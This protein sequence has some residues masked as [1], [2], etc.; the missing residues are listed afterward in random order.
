MDDSFSHSFPEP[1][2]EDSGAGPTNPQDWREQDPL[3]PFYQERESYYPQDFYI[4][5][6]DLPAAAR[7]LIWRE[8]E[9]AAYLYSNQERWRARLPNLAMVGVARRPWNRLPY[10]PGRQVEEKYL[11]WT[12]KAQALIGKFSNALDQEKPDYRHA[13]DLCKQI[14]AHNPLRRS[15]LLVGV[16]SFTPPWDALPDAFLQLDQPPVVDLPSR[17]DL[18]RFGLPSF[19]PLVAEPIQPVAP[20]SGYPGQVVTGAVQSGI[21]VAGQ[22]GRTGTLTAVGSQSGTT[23]LLGARHVLGSPNDVLSWNNS[24]IGEVIQELPDWDAALACVDPG[25]STADDI[26]GLTLRPAQPMPVSSLVQDVLFYGAT[27]GAHTT[28]AVLDQ[29]YARPDPALAWQIGNIDGFTIKGHAKHGDSGALIL[30]GGNRPGLSLNPSLALLYSDSMLG[31]LIA[32]P[33]DDSDA[34]MPNTFF[35]RSVFEIAGRL[36]L[37]FP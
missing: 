20:Y 8:R 4:A 5:Q 12:E 26:T 35:C 37:N 19:L 3:R 17:L 2:P 32:G 14:E 18:E 27:S 15:S 13:W 33:A 25:I 9:I 24:R 36:N 6:S 10:S 16:L 11:R 22:N 29:V 21:E 31:M 7:A 28:D 23:V 1:D 34:N 30:A